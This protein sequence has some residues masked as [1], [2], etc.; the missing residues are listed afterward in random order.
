MGF[1]S[2]EGD[3][4]IRVAARVPEFFSYS[5]QLEKN[6]EFYPDPRTNDFKFLTTKRSL[7]SPT[8][9]QQR[10]TAKTATSVTVA[11]HHGILVAVLYC[12]GLSIIN[13]SY[14]R[15]ASLG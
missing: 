7:F 2:F 1:W 13:V 5:H 4:K 8:H 10:T 12:S 9:L 15:T 11:L 14:Q 3:S 6:I